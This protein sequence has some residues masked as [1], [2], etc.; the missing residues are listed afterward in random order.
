M[1]LDALHDSSPTLPS[2]FALLILIQSFG[3]GWVLLPCQFFNLDGRMPSQLNSRSMHAADVA[4]HGSRSA[5]ALA[6]KTLT[7]FCPWHLF[8]INVCDFVS[9]ILAV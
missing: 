6:F 5:C 1:H 9:W 7:D 4:C 8:P 3:F 2:Q